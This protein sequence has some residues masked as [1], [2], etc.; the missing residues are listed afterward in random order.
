MTKLYLEGNNGGDIFEIEILPDGRIALVVGHCC[1]KEV[2]HTVLVEWLTSIIANA[3]IDAGGVIPALSAVDL[4][5]EVAHGLIIQIED[6]SIASKLGRLESA[7]V[8]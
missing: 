6:N 5:G 4:P 8:T 2:N 1:V 3:V 7:D